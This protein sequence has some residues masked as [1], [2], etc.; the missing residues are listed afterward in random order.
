MSINLRGIQKLVV[1][2]CFFPYQRREEGRFKLRLSYTCDDGN[3]TLHMIFWTFCIGKK[4]KKRR[5][6]ATGI[7]KKEKKKD[8]CVLFGEQS[9]MSFTNR[10]QY[11][12]KS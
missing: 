7:F 11:V 2:F 10:C 3:Y 12:V 6:I 4:K 9:V 1:S 8:T 5:I